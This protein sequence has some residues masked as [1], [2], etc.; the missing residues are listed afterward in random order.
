M[1]GAKNGPAYPR[2]RRER[3]VFVMLPM[4][5]VSSGP[6]RHLSFRQAGLAIAVDEVRA[7]RLVAERLR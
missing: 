4:M 7:H 5:L 2:Q 1:A 6:G 3:Y